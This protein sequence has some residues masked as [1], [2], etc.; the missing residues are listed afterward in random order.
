MGAVSKEPKSWREPIVGKSA[1]RDRLAFEGSPLHAFLGLKVWLV[2]L[3]VLVVGPL[4]LELTFLYYTRVA[5][6]L[7]GSGDR[8][9]WKFWSATYG[10]PLLLP[11]I[12]TLI[13]YAYRNLSDTGIDFTQ[14]RW[15]RWLPIL[16]AVVGTA[17]VTV[18]GFTDAVNVNW[19]Q[20][21]GPGWL[22]LSL[23][24]NAAGWIHA[25]FFVLMLWWLSEFTLRLAIVVVGM[26][27]NSP[28]LGKKQASALTQLVVKVNTI[29][30]MGVLFGMLLIRDYWGQI[31]DLPFGQTWFWFLSAG[32][33]FVAAGA[34]AGVMLTWLRYHYPADE[35]EATSPRL[36]DIKRGIRTIVITWL[37]PSVGLAVWGI[38]VTAVPLA[39]EV[40][41]MIAAPLILAILGAVNVWSEVY[42]FQSRKAGIFGWS[43]C[44]AA[45]VTLLG[46]FFVSL[47]MIA[48]TDPV[49]SLE[50]L[51]WPFLSALGVDLLGGMLA[52]GMSWALARHEWF[53]KKYQDD[54]VGCGTNG[55]C[56]GAETP[57]HDIIQNLSML[58]C[59]FAVLPMFVVGYEMLGWPILRPLDSSSQISLL[60]GYSGVAATIVAFPL[61][62]NMAYIRDLEDESKSRKGTKQDHYDD[63]L[64]ADKNFS[65]AQTVIT[66]VLAIIVAMS[67]WVTII[68]RVAHDAKVKQEREAA[69]SSATP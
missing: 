19:T 47:W 39:E 34:V 37:V 62:A 55:R 35:P 27:R 24:L 25:T 22:G 40:Q 43:V 61:Y 42:W 59:L 32:S 49:S 21:E 45:G 26:A 51:T 57:E 60:F 8:G 29:L 31:K 68:D 17:L 69:R 38:A 67:L 50:G 63:Y 13:A 56:F 18:A 10:D 54:L 12:A 48:K 15:L 52:I 6:G 30:L 14:Y 66:G 20:P 23:H 16:S 4:I 5:T 11:V 36:K 1:K 58:V 9:L 44:I 65:S 7:E 28:A 53:D 46:G 33:S 41:L 3:L 64:T 2:P